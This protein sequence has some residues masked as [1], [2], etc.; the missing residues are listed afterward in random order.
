MRA[1]GVTINTF[2]DLL[3]CEI[4]DITRYESSGTAISD[5]G[6]LRCNPNDPQTITFFDAHF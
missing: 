1:N 4:D 3:D 6:A 2:R 5:E